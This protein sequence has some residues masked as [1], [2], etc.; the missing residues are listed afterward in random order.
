[1]EPILAPVSKVAEIED[2]IARVS[3]SADSGLIVM[4]DIFATQNREL[5]IALAMSH[6]LPA[7]YA[8]RYFAEGGGLISY[9]IDVDDLFRRAADYVDKILRGA[10]PSDLPIQRPHKF[11]LVINM[12]TAKSL[13]LNVPRIL[14]VRADKVIE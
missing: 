11:E 3:Q 7:A 12:K 10:Q 8:F 13:G 4:P 9:G 1:M 2:A 6:A 14:L 5:I